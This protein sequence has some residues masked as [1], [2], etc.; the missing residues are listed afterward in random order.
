MLGYRH[1][2]LPLSTEPAVGRP[3]GVRLTPGQIRS[4]IWTAY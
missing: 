2:A 3:V 1:P 4:T